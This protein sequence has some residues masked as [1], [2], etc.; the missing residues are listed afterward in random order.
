M[1]KKQTSKIS[2]DQIIKVRSDCTSSIGFEIKGFKLR[3][4]NPKVAESSADR[5]WRVFDPN[6]LPAK[7]LAEL[8]AKKPYLFASNS[9]NLRRGTDV[10]S[11]APKAEADAHLLRKKQDAAALQASIGKKPDNLGSR[12]QVQ[13]SNDY[14]QTQIS[15]KDF[16]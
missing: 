12:V 14:V 10:L 1:S 5:P 6:D 16:E 2:E 8:K 9:R 7:A 13:H 4:Q 15:A 3:W 11:Y